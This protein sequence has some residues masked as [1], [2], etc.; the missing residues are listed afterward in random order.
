MLS[1]SES[2]KEYKPMWHVDKMAKIPS[3]NIVPS[4]DILKDVFASPMACMALMI[5][6][7]R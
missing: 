7:S 3:F 5:G 4:R 6:A 2:T 1:I